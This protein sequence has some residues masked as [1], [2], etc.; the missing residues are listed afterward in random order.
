MGDKTQKGVRT[1]LIDCYIY[2]TFTGLPE[3]TGL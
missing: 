3:P 2:Q 1:R